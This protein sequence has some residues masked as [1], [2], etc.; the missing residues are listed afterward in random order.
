M[1]TARRNTTRAAWRLAKVYWTSEE[2]WSAWGLLCAVVALNLGNVYVSVRINEWNRSFYNAL[3]AFNRGE[4]FRQLGIFSILVIF[5]IAMSVY[6]LYLNQLLQIRWRRWLTGRYLNNWLA[7]RAYYQMQLGS[8]TD[9][10]DQRISEDLNQFT[11]YVMNLSV[12]LISSAASLVTFLVILWQLSGSADIPL[13]KWGVLH[14]PAY[15]VWA[16]LIYGGIGTWLTIKI[17]RPL[18]PLNFARQRFEADFRFS[19]V[20]FR[21]NAESVAVYGGEPVELGIFHERFRGVFENFRQIMKRQRCLTCFTLGYAQ[22]AVIL[23]V[24]VISPRY[25]ANQIG[26]GGLMQAVNAFSF[27]HNALSFIINAYADIAAWQAATERLSSFEERLVAIHHS[28]RASRKIVIRRG[29]GVGVA[30]D[31]IDLDL[32]DGTPLLR[33]VA[34]APT[35]G[36]AMLIIGPT[37]AGKSTLLR[38]IAGLWPFGQGEITLGKGRILFVPQRPYLPLGTL[39]GALLYPRGDNSSLLA[40]KLSAVLN[41]VGLGA[42]ARELD[43]VE[44]WSQRLSLGEQQRLA[45]A[46]ILLIK[47]AILFLDEATSALDELSEARLYGLLRAAS[48]RPT[49][50]SVGHRNTLRNFHDYIQDIAAFCPWSERTLDLR[51]MF[52]DPQPPFVLAPRPALAGGS[53][54]PVA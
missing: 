24:I 52:L 25:F 9:N 16:A 23:P 13:G 17:G 3:Q 50:V 21:E 33:G 26:L 37:G 47:P 6:A 44:N 28:V 8:A 4:L 2:K 51:H 54:I 19:L 40:A 15:L 29:P 27:V 32:P 41:E 10:P 42:L 53:S 14:I 5:A 38:A 30:V 49:V 45:F 35:R 43:V 11:T 1:H 34:F 39:A 36:A 20:R 7:G 18:V 31:D 46:R 48:W 22:V 12:G